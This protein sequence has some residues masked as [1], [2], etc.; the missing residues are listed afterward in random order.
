MVK[1]IPLYFPE[2]LL[3]KTQ[4]F[5]DDRGFFRETFRKKDFPDLPEF[6]QENHSY[7]KYGVLRG[8]HYQKSPKQIGKLIRCVSGDIYDVVV[9]IRRSSDTYKQWVGH[10]LGGRSGEMIYVPPGFAHGFVVLSEEA[11]I[12]YSVTDYYSSEHDCNIKYND[13][14]L[15]IDWV[16]K[17]KYIKTSEKDTH[18]RSLLMSIPIEEE[19][20]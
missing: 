2:V 19:N 9:D 10:N 3:I 6:V 15:G 16:I 14:D 8:L 20:E 4:T 5:R 7:S 12:I 18:A 17:D 11:N 13:P 1:T